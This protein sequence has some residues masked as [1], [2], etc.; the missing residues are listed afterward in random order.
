M[1]RQRPGRRSANGTGTGRGAPRSRHGSETPNRK[2]EKPPAA[3]V[4]NGHRFDFH[5]H[6][7]QYWPQPEVNRYDLGLDFTVE[8][9]TR[10]MDAQGISDGLLLQLESAPGVEA[11]L[12][13]AELMFRASGGRLWPTS[14]VDPTRGADEVAHA[15]AL[16]GQNPELRAIKLYPG[17]RHFYPH[18]E[19]LAPVYRFAAERQIP[20]LYHQGDTLDPMGKIKFSRPIEV[21]EVAVDHRDVNFVLC[22]L[23]NPWVEEAAEVV[24]KN[25]NVYTDTSGLVWSPR[26]PYYER[27]IAR[28]QRRMENALAAMGTVDRVLYGSDW[29]L[30]SLELATRMIESL[31][32]PRAEKDQI[33]GGNAR[34]LLGKRRRSPA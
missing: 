21:D 2:G 32:Y 7:S 9:L 5:L 6:L 23:G 4:G 10:E 1:T 14:T 33:L 8:G 11:T 30:E 12:E 29:P 3:A 19:R 26:L 24:Y 31:D 27:Q 17:Y 13:E 25:E 28:A 15:V 18:D 22:H 16:W 34:R 20:V